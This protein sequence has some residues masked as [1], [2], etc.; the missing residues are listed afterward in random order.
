MAPITAKLYEQY[1]ETGVVFVAIAG[2]F[3][4]AS[5]NTVAGFIQKYNSNLT[6]VYDSTGEVF[7]KYGVTG[8]PTFFNLFGS[9]EI[10]SSYSGET[11]YDT[12]AG[13]ID[14]AAQP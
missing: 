8:V 10:S 2:P 11:S 14:L 9:G 6:Y 5:P 13:A 12:L 3:S 4:G 7:Q 1:A